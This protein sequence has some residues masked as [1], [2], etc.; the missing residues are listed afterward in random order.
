MNY[1]VLVIGGGPG[2]CKAAELAGKAGLKVALFE[3]ERLGGVCL[4]HG[5]V[6]TKS[7]LYGI[8]LYRQ[9]R[10]DA[11]MFGVT[12]SGAEIDPVVL[13]KR[14]E[15]TMNRMRAALRCRLEDAHVDIIHGEAQWERMKSGGFE[16]HVN[17]KSY[18]GL[19]LILATGARPIIPEIPGI[20]EGLQC[21]LVVTPRGMLETPAVPRSMIIL[22]GGTI[23]MEFATIYSGL[24][25]K[26]TVIEKSAEIGGGVDQ[27]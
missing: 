2:G 15:R 23:G 11:P 13:W 9:M 20:Q 3:K 16:I 8:K 4:N 6:P 22:G 1:D 17:G 25:T 27:C 7:L 18:R 10:Y 19:H 24:G 21:G 12:A 26:V 14:A 5:C